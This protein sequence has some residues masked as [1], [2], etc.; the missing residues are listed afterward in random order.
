MPKASFDRAALLLA[1]VVVLSWTTLA[2]AG[3]PRQAIP[4]LVVKVRDGDTVQMLTDDG[5]RI[6]VRLNAIDAPEKAHGRMRGQP[7]AER[8]R[9]NLAQFAARKRATLLH[10]TM[11]RYGR[12]VGLLAVETAQGAIDAGW[13]QVQS[14]YAWV[15]ERYIEEIPPRLRLRYREAQVQAREER[16]GL[17]ADARPVA[18]WDWRRRQASP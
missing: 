1:A 12:H 15:Y 11:D 9:I 7:N 13:W 5:R 4:G 8:S 6:E 2:W 17:W 10:T 14:G 16:L 3:D 18:P